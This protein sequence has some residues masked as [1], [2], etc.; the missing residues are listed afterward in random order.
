[1]NF[2]QSKPQFITPDDEENKVTF[3][4][5]AGV[6]EAKAELEE[7]VDFLK[8]PRSILRLEREFLRVYCSQGLQELER[9]SWLELLPERQE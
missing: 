7:I 5:V 9:H 6:K 2:G 3:K 4:D 1:M 8:T